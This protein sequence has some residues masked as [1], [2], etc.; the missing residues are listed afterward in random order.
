M[1]IVLI[2]PYVCY[3]YCICYFSGALVPHVLLR[4]AAGRS[5]GAVVVV[6]KSVQPHPH[7]TP[8][9]V[10]GPLMGAVPDVLAL[11]AARHRSRG[12]VESCLGFLMNLATL[13]ANQGPLCKSHVVPCVH[14]ALQGHVGSQVVATRGV[15]LL[16]YL[17]GDRGNLVR[18]WWDDWCECVLVGSLKGV[19]RWVLFV[20]GVV[21]ADVCCGWCLL[22]VGCSAE[23]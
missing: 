10:Q 20:G 16:A 19:R 14:R 6:Q 4:S 5:A 17:C 8:L 22:G 21:V 2:A 23:V 7:P 11:C 1:V 13:P 9:A 3:V 15:T 12:T 18:F